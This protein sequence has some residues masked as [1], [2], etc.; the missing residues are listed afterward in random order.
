MSSTISIFDALQSLLTS[1]MR[2]SHIY[3]A[4]ILAADQARK[5]PETKA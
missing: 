4:F 5:D 1:R 3:Q 2:M